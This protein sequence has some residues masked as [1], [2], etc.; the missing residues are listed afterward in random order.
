MSIKL[1]RFT[2]NTTD[3]H[4]FIDNFKFTPAEADR[5]SNLI[6]IAGAMSELRAL[7]ESISDP[8]FFIRFNELGELV[9]DRAN[10]AKSVLN[11]E[12]K[13]V[14]EILRVIDEAVAISIDQ[15][16]LRPNPRSVGGVANM[17]PSGDVIEGR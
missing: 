14:D 2:V 4:I 3:Q 12:F 15:H 11:F 6:S 8:P 16:K 7:P 10:D 1:D 9:L 17:L 5:I 13:E